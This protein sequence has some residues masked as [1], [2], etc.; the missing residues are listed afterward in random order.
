MRGEGGDC[1][2]NKKSDIRHGT[3]RHGTA[4][5]NQGVQSTQINLF[6]GLC[7]AT[8]EVQP[9]AQ[10]TKIYLFKQSDFPQGIS[11]V[12]S[13]S[14]VSIEDLQQQVPEILLSS[15]QEMIWN[16][17]NLI[18]TGAKKEVSLKLNMV[19]VLRSE[20]SR[21]Y[22]KITIEQSPVVLLC[23][24]PRDPQVTE[25]SIEALASNILE[26]LKR[27]FEMKISQWWNEPSSEVIP[28]LFS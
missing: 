19:E 20:T 8:L 4:R 25:A 24:E 11:D 15:L 9:M 14:S 26:L 28:I 16:A 21:C 12:N 2:K 6:F 27:K 5:H 17:Y 1:K 13:V 7:C 18:P 22:L 10:S 23:P 3:A